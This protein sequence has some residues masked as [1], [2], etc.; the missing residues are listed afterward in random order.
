MGLLADNFW[1]LIITTLWKL[2]LAF[3][4]VHAGLALNVTNVFPAVRVFVT[5]TVVGYS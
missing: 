2:N 5:S 3:D 1:F 4:T